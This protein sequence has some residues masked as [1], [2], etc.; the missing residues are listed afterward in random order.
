MRLR[1]SNANGFRIALTLALV[2]PTALP[3]AT[4]C[5][6]GTGPTLPNPI[7]FVAQFPIAGDFATIGSTFAN[8]FPQVSRA[9]RGGDL[10]VRYPDGTLCNL[11]REAG[12]GSAAVFQ[13][14][15]AIAVRDP[16]VY[17]DG[18]RA[19][20]SMVIGAP[21]E[22]YQVT[23]QR[24]QLYEVTGLGQG[25]PAAIAKVPN[26]PASYN[27]LTPLYV[28][29]GRIV[30]TSDRPRDGSLHLYP[31]HDEYESTPTNTGLWSLDPATGELALLD[32]APSGDFT[33][34][35]DSFGR[36]IFTR[37]DHLQRDQQADADAEGAGYGTFN[38]ADESAGAARLASR[39]EV[40]PEPRGDSPPN[41][42][43]HRF[44]HFFPWQV[45]PDGTDAETLNHVGRHELHEYFAQSFDDDP[46]LDEFIDEVS[47]RANANEIENF[48]QIEEDP[49]A[50][51][52]FF[53]V[54]APEFGT[55]A[56]GQIVR[57]PGDPSLPADQMAV[58]YV[59]HPA[60]ATVVA[61]GATPPAAH[62]GHYR[63]PLPMTGGALVSSHA[64]E[65]RYAANEGTRNAPSPRY[66]FRLRRLAFDA[67][68]GYWEAGVALTPGLVRSIQ[69]WD[70]D[71]LVS[72]D[73]PLWELSPVE[74]RARP[75]PPARTSSLPAPEAQ[76]FAEE[77]VD[78]EAFRDDL[79]DR[80][81][82]LI[83]SRDVTTRDAADR[84]QPFNLAVAGGAQT[85]GDGGTVYG[86]AY[87]QLFQGD[88]I[89]GIG[90]TASPDPGRRVLA[91]FL[92]D[93]ADN[94]PAPSGPPGSVALGV[95]GSLAALVPA[96]RAMTWQLTDA[97]G[98]PVV[99]ERYW[100]TFQPGEI[101]VCA[102][103]HGLNSVDQAGQPHPV[104]APA[105]LRTLLAFW[106]SRPLFADGFES[107][108]VSA[109]TTAVGD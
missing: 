55:H 1:F 72:Y 82:A 8:H 49:A 69:Y 84:Q 71:E 67:G 23:S 18:T 6:A 15:N 43:G 45:N 108:G 12:Y 66:D 96:R 5:T 103:C 91:Q 13:G 106:K 80:G 78:V 101:R 35:L 53:G 48:F 97:A 4:L 34:I 25:Q 29:G 40:F 21:T 2:A 16:S 102:S 42:N 63:D 109:W 20:F 14:A 3:A 64:F 33:P 90:G 92:H 54:E 68:L 32:H 56:S 86:V 31:Q 95:D 93:V 94:P 104:N 81:L 75:Q 39:E 77:G 61:D 9:G 98:A 79:R 36:V 38:Y 51:G 62:S 107:G 88:Q 70:P 41:V 59:T 74:V 60:T 83:V 100:L 105:A 27:N 10:Y 24:W 47:G 44:N 22:R 19:L 37:W 17:W 26:Q 65:T 46:S 57:L 87:L 50:A 89:R 99:R 28:P 85:T 58:T 11:T 73:G 30:F 7:L 52:T 76:V